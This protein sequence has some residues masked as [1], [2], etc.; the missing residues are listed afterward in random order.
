M[1]DG[2]GKTFVSWGPGNSLSHKC[3]HP[4]V[5]M[6]A[7]AAVLAGFAATKAVAQ[8]NTAGMST[9]QSWTG[10]PNLG[11]PAQH[12]V[13]PGVP[14]SAALPIWPEVN[15]PFL[16]FAKDHS[17]GYY[18]GY[19]A[20]GSWIRHESGTVY[21]FDRARGTLTVGAASLDGVPGDLTPPKDIGLNRD[22]PRRLHGLI[23]RGG[24]GLSTLTYDLL[25]PG[26]PPHRMTFT[27]LMA[28]N[29]NPGDWAWIGDPSQADP[30]AV[31]DQKVS[32]QLPLAGPGE[33]P[34]SA[35]I[36]TVN[37]NGEVGWRLTTRAMTAVYFARGEHGKLTRGQDGQYKLSFT[38]VVPGKAD[39]PM[40]LSVE[41]AKTVVNPVLE[42]GLLGPNCGN[43]KTAILP[44]R[45]YFGQ[46]IMMVPPLLDLSDA[47]VWMDANKHDSDALM[48]NLLPDGRVRWNV[49]QPA[50]ALMALAGPTPA[51]LLQGDAV[52]GNGAAHAIQPSGGQ[53]DPNM[54]RQ[55]APKE[56][57]FKTAVVWSYTD[58]AIPSVWSTGTAAFEA[59]GRT[60]EEELVYLGY[61]AQGS[62]LESCDGTA[63]YTWDGV[64][65]GILQ[66]P[67]NMS[68]VPTDLANP[69]DFLRR[70]VAW[71][72]SNAGH[73]TA[74]NRSSASDP[75]DPLQA[76]GFIPGDMGPTAYSTP[77][78]NS[79][80]GTGA[81]IANGQLTYKDS[82]SGA[83]VTM[84]VQRP[85]FMTAQPQ[86]LANVGI[87][88]M[89][90]WV[91]E[92]RQQARVL[93]VAQDG[94]VKATVVP[95]Q[96]AITMIGAQH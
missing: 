94:S 93:N 44:F 43:G 60:L 79:S 49:V 95:A 13:V 70:Y 52:H 9:F 14:M 22:H 25:E 40:N 90:I 29:L 80:G 66:M 12:D 11:V 24:D 45:P 6:A 58:S 20:Q 92:D 74:A 65:P 51:D 10:D 18:A 54:P 91:S 55:S 17:V 77:V 7:V 16:L 84:H 39:R 68:S 37:S 3:F 34:G 71:E 46:Q 35:G 83:T 56:P 78:G 50:I 30:I 87:T 21:V 53:D 69:S 5:L 32:P 15:S 41:H 31:A 86:M 62:W 19:N 28:A 72:V 75:V 27:G 61:N 36:V 59:I 8:N 81:R 89:W 47:W 33:A 57:P 26:K 67:G 23:T 1:M 63:I 4:L 64:E 88:G 85:A 48:F 2:N 38:L 73:P 82:Q 96:T 42:R 76:A